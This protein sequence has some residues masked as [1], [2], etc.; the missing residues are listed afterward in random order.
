MSTVFDVVTN[1]S[2]AW[3]LWH[4]SVDVVLCQ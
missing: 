4:E 1:S 3:R 2:V